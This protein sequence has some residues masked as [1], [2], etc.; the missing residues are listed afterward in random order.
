MELVADTGSSNLVI[1]NTSSGFNTN[2]LELTGS[3]FPIFYGGQT[4]ISVQNYIGFVDFSCGAGIPNY[5]IGSIQS[6][7][8]SACT[9]QIMG[10]AYEGVAQGNQ[11][12][13]FFADLTTTT[14]MSNE[15]STL[16]CGVAHD[17]NSQIIFGG[18]NSSLGS[19]TNA[20]YTP[21]KEK[22]WYVLNA[23]SAYLGSVNSDNK[24]GDFPEYPYPNGGTP[25][26]QAESSRTCTI[27]DS[28]TTVSAI[29][30]AM[31]SAMVKQIQAANSNLP[32]DE[33]FWAGEKELVC[34]SVRLA[35]L[36]NIILTFEGGLQ[37]TIRPESYM[38]STQENLCVFGFAPTGSDF[39][40]L[41]QAVMENQYIHFDRKNNRIGFIDGFKACGN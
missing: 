12:H 8:G 37:L 18:T 20:N 26:A 22:S 1:D 30:S 2:N 17:G 3:P 32:T 7:T 34:S 29:P 19:F 28:G 33:K 14:G 24:L 15:F 4:T 36:P 38:K 5:Y 10:L 11:D 41:G 35:N 25:C 21:V 13:T 9:P 16:L 23:T 31:H 40:I 39:V 27:L 6:C